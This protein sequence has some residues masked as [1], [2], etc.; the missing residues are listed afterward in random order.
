MQGLAQCMAV[1]LGES[2]FG[3]L[4]AVALVPLLPYGTARVNKDR[5]ALATQFR[6]G[7]RKFES[8]R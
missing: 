1:E 8:Q 5:F 3:L 4:A 6:D 2:G 7:L